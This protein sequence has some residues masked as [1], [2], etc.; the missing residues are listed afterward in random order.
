VEAGCG[1]W[2]WRLA[3]EDVEAV[4]T[5]AEAE[6]TATTVFVVVGVCLRRSISTRTTNKEYTTIGIGIV[7]IPTILLLL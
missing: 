5:E 7:V 3:V 4:E 2:L 1:G 6:A